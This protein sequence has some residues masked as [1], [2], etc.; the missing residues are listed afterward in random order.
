[1]CSEQY[2]TDGNVEG[3]I[4]RLFANSDIRYIHV[5]DTDAGCYD[6]RVERS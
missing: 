2:V 3:V 5:R 4:D 1:L 6:F